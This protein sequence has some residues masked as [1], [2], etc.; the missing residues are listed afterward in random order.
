MRSPAWRGAW[1]AGLTALSAVAGAVSGFVH[2]STLEVLGMQV[3]VGLLA[4]LA[5]LLGLVLLARLV[6]QS[7]PAV[8]LVS[9]A[10]AL[11]VLLLSQFRPEGDLVVNEDIWGLTLLGGAALVVTAGVVVPFSAYHGVDAPSQDGV[12]A[13]P[14]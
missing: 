9:A 3:P 10:F 11:P 6:G 5:A 14:P 4:A 13:N 12:R 7:R 2:R 8:L 1:L